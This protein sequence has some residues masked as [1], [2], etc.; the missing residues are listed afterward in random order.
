MRVVS[1]NAAVDA[2]APTTHKQTSQTKQTMQNKARHMISPS[3]NKYDFWEIEHR[4]A[5][6]TD[7]S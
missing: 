7:S 4:T 2:S 3:V 5:R 6:R 1:D